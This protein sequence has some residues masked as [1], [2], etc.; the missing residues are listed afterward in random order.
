MKKLLCFV[1]AVI[2]LFCVCGCRGKTYNTNDKLNIVTTIFPLYDFARAVIGEDSGL[3]LLIRPGSEVHSYDPSP[4]DMAAIYDCDLFLYIGGESDTWVGSMLSD[5]GV[6][7][8]SF[9]DKVTTLNEDGEDEPDEH[10]WTS[11]ENAEKMLEIICDA[12]CSLDSGNSEK[13]RSNTQEYKARIA[14][15]SQE[16][17]EV[18]QSHDNP[19]I[20]VA[21]RFPFKY[22][23]SQYGISYTAA[24]GGCAASADISVKT[25]S[26][27]MTAAKENNISAVYCTELSSRTVANALSEQTGVPVLELNSGHNVTL[28]DFENG[29]T[30]V[31]LLYRNAGALKKGLAE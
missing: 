23:V 3:T 8:L 14:E 20:L 25:M 19:Y 24:F 10:I 12:V 1:L 15:A 11:P 29:V 5:S 28:S 26:L 6:N 17:K 18:V 30:Y 31:D 16:I 4:S 22:F 2:L 9:I 13:Y 7:A 21:D 27:L